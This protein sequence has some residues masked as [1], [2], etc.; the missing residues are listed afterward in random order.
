MQLQ[1]AMNE[2]KM[3]EY[4]KGWILITNACNSLRYFAKA[5]NATKICNTNVEGKVMSA[6][7]DLTDYANIEWI[8][9]ADF[10]M[11]CRAI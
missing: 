2:D 8:F 7:L 5:R 4:V 11:E 1:K 6:E 10:Q 9:G 3:E